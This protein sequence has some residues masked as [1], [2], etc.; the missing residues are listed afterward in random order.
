VCTAGEI[1]AYKA[2][3]KVLRVEVET[4]EASASSR[5]SD[6]VSKEVEKQ[7]QNSNSSMSEEVEKRSQALLEV[8]LRRTQP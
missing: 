8:V 1:K 7:L 2:E 3:A 6:S 4:L 5:Y